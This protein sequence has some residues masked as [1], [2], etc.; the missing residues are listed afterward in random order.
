MLEGIAC[1]CLWWSWW[2]LTSLF[3]I[4]AIWVMKV[5]T[6]RKL[7]ATSGMNW[8]QSAG[9]IGNWAS[10]ILPSLCLRKWA[11]MISSSTMSTLRSWVYTRPG[12]RWRSVIAMQNQLRNI[13]CGII[14][15]LVS[16]LIKRA[17]SPM[18]VRQGGFCLRRCRL[19]ASPLLAGN[20]N[21]VNDSECIIL[22]TGFMLTW[23]GAPKMPKLKFTYNTKR[24]MKIKAG[25]M[26]TRRPLHLFL[27]CI[28]Q[29]GARSY[30]GWSSTITGTGTLTSARCAWARASR[31]C[32]TPVE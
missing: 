29:V 28:T 6:Y 3:S 15:T 16:R 24:T 19:K 9:S 4:G 5:F 1:F 26:E 30:I 2:V 12:L 21:F 11:S 10:Q 8:I 27:I 32:T 7:W 20:F 22:A 18:G 14:L 25:S 13:W 23:T 31:G 17:I